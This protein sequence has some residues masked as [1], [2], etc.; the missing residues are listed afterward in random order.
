MPE[1]S[2]NPLL[3]PAHIT[4]KE[5]YLLS[6]HD[7][8]VMALFELSKKP[9]LITAYYD[10]GIEC[11]ITT[12]V[13]VLQERNLVLLEYGPNSDK[14][15]Q[16]LSSGTATCLSKHNDIDIRFQ[17]DGL[18]NARYRG[19]QVFAAPIPNS[20]LR[21]QR[22]EFFRVHMP[23]MDPVTC[24]F[25]YRG[26]E[27]ELPLADISIGGLALVDAEEQCQAIKGDLLLRCIL[28]FPNKGGQMEVDLEV[29]DSFLYGRNEERKVR[30]LGCAFVDLNRSQSGFIQRYINRL[31]IQQK[32][33]E[34]S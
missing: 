25:S 27:L 30:R 33:L 20:L 26:R 1:T 34:Y 17:L 4:D 7:D 14:N 8:I 29:R 31:Q 22:R 24:R 2:H 9:D 21:L 3:E 19:E 23:V 11:I 15:R 10:S 12:V 28:T 32:N 13:D 5:K 18:Q 16:L 6:S